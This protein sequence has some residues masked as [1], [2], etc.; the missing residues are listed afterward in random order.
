MDTGKAARQH[1]RECDGRSYAPV[2]QRVRI[3][4]SDEPYFYADDSFDVGVA[5]AGS[6]ANECRRLASKPSPQKLTVDAEAA[7]DLDVRIQHC[8][9]HGA[10]LVFG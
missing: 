9:R 8:G 5:K 4:T 1:R 2:G 3:S 7:V 6:R 10:R